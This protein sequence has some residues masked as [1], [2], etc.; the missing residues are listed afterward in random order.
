MNG[1]CFTDFTLSPI[2]RQMTRQ[3]H[4]SYI[5][6]YCSFLH[7]ISITKYTPLLFKQRLDQY[8]PFPFGTNIHRTVGCQHYDTFINASRTYF[9]FLDYCNR[10]FLRFVQ[11]CLLCLLHSYFDM[12]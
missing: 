12:T 8:S 9:T 5:N 3:C 4:V 6:A 7:I 11:C 10:A 2:L 1:I